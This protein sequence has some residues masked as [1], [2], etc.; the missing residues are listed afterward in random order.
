[1]LRGGV[2]VILI[3]SVEDGEIACKG[4]GFAV[5]QKW[6]FCSRNGLGKSETKVRQ[7]RE[8]RKFCGQFLKKIPN[9]AENNALARAHKLWKAPSAEGC[10]RLRHSEIFFQIGFWFSGGSA[11]G[12]ASERK[13][14]GRFYKL[15]FNVRQCFCFTWMSSRLSHRIFLSFI[16]SR[17]PLRSLVKDKNLRHDSRKYIAS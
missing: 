14:K 10:A 2:Y 6:T 9:F 11:A 13:T 17:S 5:H 8:K 12:Y 3:M 7:K 4:K 1:M 15:V 16:Q